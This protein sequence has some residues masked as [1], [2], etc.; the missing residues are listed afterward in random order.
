MPAW[1][2]RSF[3]RLLSGVVIVHQPTWHN[4]PNN[5]VFLSRKRAG[6]L[7]AWKELGTGGSLAELWHSSPN[8]GTVVNFNHA[9]STTQIGLADTSTFSKF[10]VKHPQR[11][12]KTIVNS[13]KSSPSPQGPLLQVAWWRQPANDPTKMRIKILTYLYICT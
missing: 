3:C 1:S 13:T 11:Y 8:I 6:T 5:Q 10:Q 2:F 7:P 12:R 4:I 9:S